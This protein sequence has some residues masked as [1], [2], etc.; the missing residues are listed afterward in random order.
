MKT[1]KPIKAIPGDGITPLS[2]NNNQLA[3]YTK[4][5][6]YPGNI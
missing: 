3:N 6:Y 2:Y 5:Y 4:P 1:L